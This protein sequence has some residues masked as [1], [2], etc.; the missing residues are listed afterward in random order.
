MKV[1]FKKNVKGKGK[2]G[3][4]KEVPDGYAMNFL[5]T[6]GYAVRATDDVIAHHTQQVTQ[7]HQ[8]HEKI[9]HD[10]KEKFSALRGKSLTIII[11][12]KDLKGNLYKAVRIEEIISEIRSKLHIIIDKNFAKHYRPIKETGEHV[13]EFIFEDLRTSCTIVIK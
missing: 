4:I 7:E 10:V 2:I 13:V 11:P 3:E 8:E 5:I 9:Y 12:E 6:Q 1:L